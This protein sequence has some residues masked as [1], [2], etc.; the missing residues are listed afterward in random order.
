VNELFSSRSGEFILNDPASDELLP[1]KGPDRVY[2][3]RRTC[4]FEEILSQK[5]LSAA[6]EDANSGKTLSD[7]LQTSSFP[8]T[9]E[10]LLFPFLAVEFKSEKNAVGFHDIQIQTALPI[11]VLLQLQLRLRSAAR[12]KASTVLNPLVWFFAFRGDDVRLYAAY[13]SDDG[14]QPKYVRGN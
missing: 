8:E 11:W 3:L 13:P 6:K 10:P 2:G 4:E 14:L 5:Y 1:K 12:T 9:D 7:T